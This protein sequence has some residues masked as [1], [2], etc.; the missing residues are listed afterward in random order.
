IN[1]GS[2]KSTSIND[3]ISI[4]EKIVQKKAKIIFREQK[5]GEIKNFTVNIKKLEEQLGGIPTTSLEEG[6]KHT[7][8]W[9]QKRQKSSSNL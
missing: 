9:F 5:K 8:N 2:G 3:V 7:Y 1:F 6:L 4:M